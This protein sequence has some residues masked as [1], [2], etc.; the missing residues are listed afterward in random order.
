VEIIKKLGT[1]SIEEIKDMNPEYG[2]TKFPI[3]KA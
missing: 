1:P 2:D 3:L